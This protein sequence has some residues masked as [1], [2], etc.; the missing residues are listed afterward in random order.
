MCILFNAD[1]KTLGQATTEK[2]NKESMNDAC[3]THSFQMQQ[4][5]DS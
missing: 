4:E 5:S 3:I 2:K 1:T